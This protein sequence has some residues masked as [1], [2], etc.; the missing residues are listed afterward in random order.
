LPPPDD[1]AR[2]D[3]IASTAST[4]KASARSTTPA[5]ASKRGVSRLTTACRAA[6]PRP[7]SRSRK[8]RPKSSESEL[9][10]ASSELEGAILVGR[11]AQL[12]AAQIAQHS[13]QPARADLRAAARGRR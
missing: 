9:K 1:A 6:A 10:R 7:S 13:L 4:S 2:P 12:H 8:R 3:Q 11:V 5:R